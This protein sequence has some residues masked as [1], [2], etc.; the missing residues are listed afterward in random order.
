[1]TRRTHRRALAGLVVGWLAVVAAL[2]AAPAAA[3]VTPAL[4]GNLPPVALE[5]V[6]STGHGKSLS[7]N[8]AKGVLSNDY[9]VDGQDLV[10]IRVSLPSHGTLTQFK[11]DGSFQ[12]KPDATYSGIDTFTYIANDGDLSSPPAIVTITVG[13]PTA[14]PKPTP[15]PTPTPTPTPRPTAVA[16][17]TPTPTPTPE[18]T[19]TP[20]PEPTPTP[21]PAQIDPLPTPTPTAR[22]TDGAAVT[23]TPT[24]PTGRDGIG[25]GRTPGPDS[26]SGAT[27]LGGGT[28]GG[29]PG[30]S[31]GPTMQI[32]PPASESRSTTV[33]VGPV[34]VALG[35]PL[36]FVVPSVAL[37]V[38]GLL[39]ILAVLA[40]GIGA[41]AW[42]PFVRRTLDRD[43]APARRRRHT[44]A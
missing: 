42:L 30:A 33:D 10:A 31:G 15:K 26:S 13:F 3:A 19:P 23:P 20:T 41:L 12:Y 27:A 43:E 9:D 18:P 37:V 25:S 22:P 8:K 21:T 14:T 17:P 44:F 2:G 11:D 7:V 38:P 34:D 1:M 16:T 35:L 28:I 4:L 5:D 6:Y 29:P 32:G 39:L 24:A 36:E 40:Q